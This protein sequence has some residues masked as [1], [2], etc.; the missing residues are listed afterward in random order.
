MKF[1]TL[2]DLLQNLPPAQAR[3]V[4]SAF[5]PAGKVGL[6]SAKLHKHPFEEGHS[7]AMS[8]EGIADYFQHGLRDLDLFR[9]A[10]RIRAARVVPLG[11]QIAQIRYH[12][13]AVAFPSRPS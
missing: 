1:S 12:V 10:V 6:G 7:V 5:W 8:V 11:E 4:A 9:K 2:P 13:I 3:E